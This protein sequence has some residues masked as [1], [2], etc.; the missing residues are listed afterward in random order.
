MIDDKK[1]TRLIPLTKWNDYHVWP[2]LGGLR[3]LYAFR[4]KK[5]CEKIFF[6][7]AGRVLI[8]EEAFFDWARDSRP[9]LADSR[10]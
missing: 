10:K 1:N 5:E 9:S 3:H 2:S 7:A 8:D 6:K 4:T